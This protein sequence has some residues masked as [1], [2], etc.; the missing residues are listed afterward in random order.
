MR[1]SRQ[2]RLAHSAEHAHGHGA[3]VRGA[4]TSQGLTL[5]ELG[6]RVGYSAAQVSRYERGIAPLTDITVLRRFA[7][8]LG[9][10]DQLFGLTPAEADGAGR[11]A[12][13]PVKDRPSRAHG[14]T[15]DHERQ[16]EDG[17]EEDMRRR[18][19]L[20]GTAA[21]AGAAAL[22][23]ARRSTPGPVVDLEDVL[24]SRAEAMPVPL[25][26]LRDSIASA[27]ADF[28]AARY[29]HLPATLPRLIAT[30]RAT[31]DSADSSEQADASTLLAGAFILAADFAVKLNDDPLAW[32]TADRALQAA[33]AGNDPLP[34]A[35]ARRAVAT[36]MRR[37]RPP[38]QG[39]LPAGPRLPRHRCRS[40]WRRRT[41]HVRH[42]AQ[43]RR[44][45]CRHRRE[46]PRGGRI[47]RRSRRSRHPARSARLPAPARIR[48]AG[49]TL[50]QVSIAQVL[51]DNGTAIEHARKLR[52]ASIPNARAATGSMSPAL[53]TSGESPKPATPR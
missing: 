39:L 29:D 4:R 36:A 8:V 20:A 34:L 19:L 22:G 24:Y 3:I 42:A 11:H 14:N 53:T 25:A 28:R 30:A 7:A 10:P 40:A 6:A 37:T 44:L 9:I 15:V 38:G 16:W 49:V 27:R 18:E 13:I 35:D 23:S 52:P 33:Q 51:G 31:S 21:L 12:V 26:G 32:M 2:P 43:R 47:P 45:H 50:Y 48:P 17:D 5:A 1:S 46:P 41:R